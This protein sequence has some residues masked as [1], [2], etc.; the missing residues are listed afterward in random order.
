[1]R[2]LCCIPLA[3]LGGAAWSPVEAAPENIVRTAHLQVRGRV[4][5]SMIDEAAELGEALYAH[6][7]K[8]FVTEP[9]RQDLPLQ[10][11]LHPDA[12]SFHRELRRRGTW[13]STREVGGYTWFGRGGSHVA[14]QPHAFDTRRLVIHELTHQFQ[15]ACRPPYLRGRGP[16]WYREGLAEY[17]GWHR[18]TTAGI[19]FG[20]LDIVAPTRRAHD[21]RRRVRS[22]YWQPEQFLYGGREADYVDALALV[23]GL[24]SSEDKRVRDEFRK[25]ELAVLTLGAERRRIKAAFSD[26]V[27]LKA[28]LHKTWDAKGPAWS[29]APSGWDERPDG[30]IQGKRS[31]RASLGRRVPAGEAV[32]VKI[33][34]ESGGW[35][36]AFIMGGRRFTLL[37][38][39]DGQIRVRGTDPLSWAAPA[40]ARLD[41]GA[42]GTLRLFGQVDGGAP[43]H[44]I[45]GAAP[46][47]WDLRLF[48]RA[49]AAAF[50]LDPLPRAEAAGPAGK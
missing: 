24:L 21:A 5:E 47:R 14:K 6:L 28:A 32:S 16:S 3:L 7:K 33:Q 25:W 50:R 36:R 41:M 19:Q 18:R 15:Y 35:V 40:G 8:H 42:D 22:T 46:G 9:G 23:G 10:L 17:F 31:R 48:V 26:P 1:M 37:E 38:W 2:W 34:P 45:P 27:K 44:T 20:A 43:V 49:G 39:R 12:A 30:W 4:P 11:T 13:V 29:P